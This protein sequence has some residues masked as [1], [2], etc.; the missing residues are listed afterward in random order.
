MK[1]LFVPYELAVK[2]KEKGFDDRGMLAFW[3]SSKH[4]SPTF[5]NPI[6]KGWQNTDFKDKVGAPL[7]QQVVDL[8]RTKKSLNIYVD[9]N[10]NTTEFDGIVRDLD[11]NIISSTEFTND[12][13][14][15]FNGGIEQAL[16]LI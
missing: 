15:A 2:L 10:K 12:Y 8:F 6:E 9:P 16:K 4:S 11:A 7:Y 1:H 13:Y 5:C 14:E 3:E